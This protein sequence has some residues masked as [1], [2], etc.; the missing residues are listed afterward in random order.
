MGCPHIASIDEKH[1]EVYYKH[2]SKEECPNW[3]EEFEVGD[4]VVFNDRSF[5]EGKKGT[6]TSIK[7]I[8]GIPWYGLK[9]EDG[10]TRGG[11]YEWLLDKIKEK[12]VKE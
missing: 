2:S 4:K 7:L 3:V 10:T 11:Q 9:M 5:L 1:D 6:I 8:G 12:R